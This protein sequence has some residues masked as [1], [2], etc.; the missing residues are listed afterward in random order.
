MCL[1]AVKCTLGRDHR[2]SKS[3]ASIH[4]ELLVRLAAQHPTPCSLAAAARQHTAPL[5]R[6]PVANTLD[7]C[8]HRSTALARDGRPHQF[9][10]VGY[11]RI[12]HLPSD[13][14]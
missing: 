10:R 7:A 5:V 3:S 2:R 9:S 14:T 12:R 1:V 4:R 6:I 8:R 13:L 11:F